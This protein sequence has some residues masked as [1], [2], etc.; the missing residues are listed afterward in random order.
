MMF[1]RKKKILFFALTFLFSNF[2]VAQ[3]LELTVYN[4]NFALVK[5]QRYFDLKKGLNKIQFQDVAALIEPTSVYFI[6]LSDPGCVILEQNYEYDLVSSDKLLSKYID[7]NIKVITED[8]RIFEGRLLSYDKDN[9]II[10]SSE[11]L[12]MITRKD[13]I[14]QII[15]EKISEGFITKPTLV[16]KVESTKSGEHLTEVSYLTKRV[17]WYC[18]YVAVLDNED[19]SM[20]LDGWVSITNQSGATFKNAK[21]KLI[22]GEVKRARARLF[23]REYIRYKM[24]EI[25][26]PQF[27]E[28]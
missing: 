3:G 5:D 14:A 24:E 18:E 25:S 16:W 13:N 6:S 2:L 10:S 20:D 15:F 11:G 27:K 17:N 7:K 26:K 1:E 21:L 22:A 9:L 8:E 12:N 4:Q 23:E 28:K 19:R